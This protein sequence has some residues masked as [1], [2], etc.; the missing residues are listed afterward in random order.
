MTAVQQVAEQFK[1]PVFATQASAREI[2]ERH[3]NYTFRTH[4]IDA[5]RVTIWNRWIKERGFKPKQ[6]VLRAFFPRERRP[7]GLRVLGHAERADVSILRCDL[8]G[9]RVPALPLDR[10]GKGAVTG[11]PVVLVGF[12]AGIEAMARAGVTA[13]AHMPSVWDRRFPRLAAGHR[14]GRLR[15]G[16]RLRSPDPAS[17]A[18]RLGPHVRPRARPASPRPRR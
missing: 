4:V 6:N 11:Q 17:N 5:D 3:L 9:I 13:P 7:F 10:T 16:T 8:A 14:R 1:V 2:T 18:S 12:P 15:T